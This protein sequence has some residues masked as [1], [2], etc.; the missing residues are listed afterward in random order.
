MFTVCT[1]SDINI[2]YTKHTAANLHKTDVVGVSL[3]IF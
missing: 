2:L 1:E 3:Y